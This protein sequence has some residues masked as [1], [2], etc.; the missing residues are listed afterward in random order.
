MPTAAFNLSE[1]K[2]T[3][4]PLDPRDKVETGGAE[5]NARLSLRSRTRISREERRW[6]TSRRTAWVVKNYG[7]ERQRRDL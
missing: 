1:I 3:A 4:K 7:Q 6:T 5:A 2:V